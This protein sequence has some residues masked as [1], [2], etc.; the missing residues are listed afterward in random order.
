MADLSITISN[1]LNIIG[2]TPASLWNTMEWGTDNWGETKNFS[3]LIF[4]CFA[5]GI[6]LSEV[7]TF[8]F[9]KTVS[10]SLIISQATDLVA[11]QDADG[12]DY[13]LKGVTDPSDRV[14]PDYTEDTASSVSYTSVT[15]SDPG[16]SDA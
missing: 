5:N 2:P 15:G 6:S 3:F 9:Q 12:Y 7:W 13:V 11:L 1:G 14:C 4:K 16:W 8:Q 10:N